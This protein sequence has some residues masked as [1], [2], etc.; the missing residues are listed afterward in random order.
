MMV[1]RRPYAVGDNFMDT[2]KSDLMSSQA[3]QLRLKTTPAVSIWTTAVNV[4]K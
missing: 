4:K 2:A 3:E 1:N